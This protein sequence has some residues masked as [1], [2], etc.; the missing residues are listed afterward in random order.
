[1]TLDE[2]IRFINSEAEMANVEGL[3]ETAEG[4]MEVMDYLK[5]YDHLRAIVADFVARWESR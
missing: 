1:M 3:P 4:F 5:E 2:A